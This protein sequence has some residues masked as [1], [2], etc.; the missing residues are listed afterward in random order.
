[1][2]IH[3]KIV[4]HAESLDKNF[5]KEM[6]SITKNFPDIPDSEV[7]GG[8]I[9]KTASLCIAANYLYGFDEDLREQAMDDFILHLYTII[10]NIPPST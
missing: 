9:A 5:W 3:Q 7:V 6:K 1:M 2:N 4:K 10:D 8:L